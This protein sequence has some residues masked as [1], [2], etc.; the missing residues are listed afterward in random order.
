MDGPEAVS[1]SCKVS[2]DTEMDQV[3]DLRRTFMGQEVD[4]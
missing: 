4:W 1:E 3:P 2:I